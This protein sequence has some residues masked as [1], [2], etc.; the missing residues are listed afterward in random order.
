MDQ[1]LELLLEYPLIEQEITD[2][3]DVVLFEGCIF[4]NNRNIDLQ[5]QQTTTID[6]EH[7]Y[8]L[9][10]LQNGATQ[11]LQDEINEILA[12][13]NYQGIVTVL[14]KIKSILELKYPSRALE[15]HTEIYRKVLY[16]YSEFSK[17]FLNLKTCKLK[18]DLSRIYASVLDE[19][20]REHSVEISVDFASHLM[21][22][23]HLTVYDL[24]RKDQDLFKPQDNLTALFDQFLALVEL[25]QPYFDVMEQFDQNCTVL[26]P[27]K[28][29]RQDSYRRIWLG[30][31][32]SMIITV[33]AYN[34]FLRPDIKFLGPD[35]LTE[36]YST[37][38]NE[39]LDS[40]VCQNDIFQG[41]LDLL[42]LES[43]PIRQT[44]AKEVN[45]LV[46]YGECSICFSLRLN[47]KLPEI[48]CMNK[49]CE[50]FFH[51]QCLY[52]WLIALNAKRILNSVSGKCPN[53]E[54]L[55]SCPVLE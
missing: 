47:D 46:E 19:R 55:I 41:V 43:F 24:P 22:L 39:N 30:E 2:E 33:D 26:D 48:I 18:E 14:D 11:A 42:G 27:E 29:R 37:R 35:R 8:T 4:V 20:H 50:Q 16:E 45:L 21:E 32:I 40:W 5:V 34:I 3:T 38:L 10:K 1:S 52:E 13:D 23:F 53:C 6:E 51:N 54:T 7:K 49:S 36:P 17:F 25:L 28:P 9:T 31:N 15:N 12:K 44:S